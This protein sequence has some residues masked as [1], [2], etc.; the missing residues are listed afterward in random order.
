MLLSAFELGQ[1]VKIKCTIV[2]TESICSLCCQNLSDDSPPKDGVDDVFSDTKQ[3]LFLTLLN[4]II[5]FVFSALRSICIRS[6]CTLAAVILSQ[7]TVGAFL[8]L[9]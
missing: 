1:N 9:F 8:Q 6:R 3:F 5:A 4:S 2:E 7:G